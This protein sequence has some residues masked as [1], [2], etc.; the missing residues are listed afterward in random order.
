M[1]KA[2]I[3]KV[4]TEPFPASRFIGKC[5]T[6]A[7]RVDG[8]FGAHWDAWHEQGWFDQIDP[9]GNN[10]AIGLMYEDGDFDTTF[11]YWIGYFMPAD[12]TVPEGFAH[13]DFPASELGVCWVHGKEEDIFGQEGSCGEKLEKKYTLNANWCFERYTDRLDSPDKKGKVILDIC[14]FIK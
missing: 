2:K 13:V 6:N 9:S 8:M 12:A 14:F 10:H 7:D 4:Y 1:S 3:A 5:Y 11:Q